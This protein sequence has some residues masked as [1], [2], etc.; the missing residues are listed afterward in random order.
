MYF[1]EKNEEMR[2]DRDEITEG[3][4]RRRNID[5]TSMIGDAPLPR[6]CPT[7]TPVVSSP[8]HAIG[9]IIT[10]SYIESDCVRCAVRHICRVAASYRG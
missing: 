9:Q 5:C 7:P 2:G 1:L 8:N 6:G 4:A 10:E 3:R